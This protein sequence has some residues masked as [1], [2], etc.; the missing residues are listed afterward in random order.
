MTEGTIGAMIG[1]E[2][3]VDV[4]VPVI[5]VTP[6]P[7]P[8]EIPPK[9][10]SQPPLSKMKSSRRREQGWKLGK[11]REKRRKPWAK[12][13]LKLWHLLESPLLKVSRF[14]YTTEYCDFIT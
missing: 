9:S 14:L 8:P 10:R 6:N 5:D 13:R 11:R 3:T 1:A 4:H 7:R 2:M 12:P